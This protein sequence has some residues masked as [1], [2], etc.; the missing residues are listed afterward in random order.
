[1][2]IREDKKF[3]VYK[4]VLKESG[5]VLYVGEG[6]RE[7]AYEP[8]R[9]NTEFNKLVDLNLVETII[10]EENLTKGQAQTGESILIDKYGLDNLYN[11]QNGKSSITEGDIEDNNPVIDLLKCAI[12]I[13]FNRYNAEDIITPNHIISEIVDSIFYT[14]NFDPY[15]ATYLNPISRLGEFYKYI[16]DELGV[17]TV[18]N[19]FTMINDNID[20]AA[21]FYLVGNSNGAKMQDVKIINED[22]GDFN[23]AN[24]YDVIIMNP[25]FINKGEKFI[26]KCIDMLKPNG[27]LGCVMSPFWRSVT[28]TLGKKAYYKMLQKGG[29]HMIHMY[30][31][32]ET[33]DLFGRDIGLVDT[34]V[35]QKGAEINNTK[36]INQQGDEYQVDL[37]KYPQAPPVLPSYIYDKY[38]DQVNGIKWYRF[39]A[40]GG[41]TKKYPLVNTFTD[42]ITNKEFKCCDKTIEKSKGK[43]VIIDMN[44]KKYYIDNVVNDK[45]MFFFNNDKE[46]DTIVNA[47]DFVIDN[48]DL[49]RDKQ[50]AW[51]PGIKINE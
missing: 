47:L 10:V 13:T 6:T 28:T 20:K 39:P 40:N 14:P 18:K 12:D 15:T 35:W 25:P 51:I 30:S 46:R 22:F 42:C 21:M 17:E 50:N 19:K 2:I 23:T 37:K 45:L 44:I 38:F 16:T 31:K 3:V 34:F 36:I 33:S 48:R 4:K 11:V 27:Y 49:F 29:F 24:K 1:M 26:I 5:I 32:E 7:R 8:Y 43:K 9:S 41:N